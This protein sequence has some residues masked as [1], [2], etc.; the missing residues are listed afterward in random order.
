[1]F[2]YE[3]SGLKEDIQEL[4]KNINKPEYEKII[5]PYQNKI[6]ELQDEIIK[7]RNSRSALYSAAQ[8]LIKSLDHEYLKIIVEKE[9]PRAYFSTSPFAPTEDVRC[10]RINVPIKMNIREDFLKTYGHFYEQYEKGGE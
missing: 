8:L 9:E 5:E 4:K 10:E 3:G 2:L 7:L 1:M 6:H